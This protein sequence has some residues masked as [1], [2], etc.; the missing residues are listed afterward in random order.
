MLQEEFGEMTPQ[1]LAAPVHT[2]EVSEQCYIKNSKRYEWEALQGNSSVPFYTAG[3]VEA[4]S[5]LSEGKMK[6][7]VKSWYIKQ[8]QMIWQ[9]HMARHGVCQA[10]SAALR[11]AVVIEIIN[12][13]K[14]WP[15]II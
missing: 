1:Q 5:S 10:V 6:L 3:K 14:L 8:K 12:S 11:H 4:A 2:V 15:H 9:Q 13:L 7:S